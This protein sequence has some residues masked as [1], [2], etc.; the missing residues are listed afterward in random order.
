MNGNKTNNAV[1]LVNLGTPTAPTTGAVRRFLKSFLSDKRVVEIPRLL[2]LP[3]LYGIILPFRSKKVAKLYRAIWRDQ[4]SPLKVILTD[5][6]IALEQWLCSENNG[7]PVRVTGA[8]VYG[9]PSIED[10]VVEM[11]R[12]GI[13]KF[14][15]LPLYPQYSGT[16][17]GSVFDQYAALIR[18]SRNVPDIKICKDYYKRE[19]YIQALANS[20]RE[21]WANHGRS[22]RLLLSYHGIPQRCVDLGDPYYNQ[23]METSHLLAQALELKSEEWGVSFQSRLGKAQWLQPY[24]DQV[25]ENW[26][27][28]GVKSVDVLCPAFSADCLETIE[29]IDQENRDLFLRAGGERFQYIPCLNVREDHIQMMANIACEYFQSSKNDC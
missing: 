23:C 9:S 21:Y 22:Q 10:R 1:I 5:Q 26:G 28:S 6:V 29:E 8:M 7:S 25:L 14:L 15:V 17:T 4:G 12:E 19:D 3:I 18:K 11:Q 27:A 2:W 20:V 13:D 24:T 16:T